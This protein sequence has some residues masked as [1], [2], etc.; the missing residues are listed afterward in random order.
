MHDKY[1][2]ISVRPKEKYRLKEKNALS[3]GLIL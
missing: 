3:V 1:F 2:F